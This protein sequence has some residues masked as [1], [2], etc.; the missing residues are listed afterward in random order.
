MDV[1]GLL[2]C[3]ACTLDHNATVRNNAELQLKQISRTPGFLGACLDIISSL[4]VPENVKLSACLYFKNKITN[5]WSGAKI[6]R[7]ELLNY[8]VDNDEKPVIKDMLMRAMISCSKNS[9]RCTRVLKSAL[10]T[11]IREEYPHKRWDTLLPESVALLNE[12]D[13]DSAYVGLICLS[14]IFRTYRWKE[15]DARQSLEILILDSFPGLLQYAQE[16][17]IQDGKNI[18]NVKLGEMVKLILKMYKFVIYHDLPFVLQ[19][20]DMFIN[21]ANFFVSII[22]L[23][24]PNDVINSC[25]DELQNNYSWVKCK[26]WSYAIVFRLFQ[27]YASE[28]LTKRFN[29]DEFKSLFLT[30]FFGEYLQLLFQ[31]I[32]Q[33][34]NKKLW[35]SDASIFYV[36]SFIEQAIIQ[37]STWGNIKSHYGTILEHVI[38][39]LLM[40]SEAALETFENDPQEYIHRYSDLWNDSYAPDLAAASLLATAVSKREGTTLQPTLEFTIQTLQNNVGDFRNIP[41]QNALR[42]ESSFRIF[43][44]IIDRL[45]DEQ[46]TYKNEIE[47]FLVS[48]VFP[49]FD[50]PYGFLRSRVCEISSKVG[51]LELHPSNVETLFNGIMRNLNDSDKCLPVQLL[52]ALA[53]QA[54]INNET[55]EKGLSE[56]VVPTMQLLLQLSNDFESDTISGVMQDF[57]ENFAQQ[58][59]PFGVELMNTL[60][61]QFLKLAVELHDASNFQPDDLLNDSDLPDESEK[62]MA[63]LGILSTTCSILLSFENSQNVVKNLEQSFYPAAEFILKNDVEDFYRECCEFVENSTFLLREISPISWKIL[64]LIGEAN[65]KED[66]MVSFYLEDFMLAIN[67]YTI[68]AKKEL[69]QNDFYSKILF[70][71]YKKASISEDS[72]LDELSVVFDLSQKIILCLEG[73]MPSS[74]RQRFLED[75]ARAIVVEKDGLKKNIIFGVTAFNV[76]ISSLVTSPTVT[77]QFLKHH[78]IL[79]FFFEIWLT[80]YVPNFKRVYDIK[81]STLALLSILCQ[82][83]PDHLAALSL[84][85]VSQK[86]GCLII[87]LLSRFPAALKGLQDKRREFSLDND[88]TDYYNNHGDEIEFEEKGEDAL[89]NA[90]EDHLKAFANDPDSIKFISANEFN[91]EEDFD[92]LEEDP[93]SGSVLENI[94]IYDVFKSSM[95]GLQNTDPNRYA[96]FLQTMSAE[97]QNALNH[98]MNL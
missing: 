87:E 15:N 93:L 9:A 1:N 80:F 37:K 97:D 17:L 63:A 20:E 31:Q 21:W 46:S 82:L 5:G 34:G 73:D 77:L 86:M 92:D 39:P 76:V 2:Q 8:E 4:D 48:Y 88:A 40:P 79:E 7:N 22:Q 25:D 98:L 30:Q 84:Q 96:A 81:L 27:R 13:I 58:L 32:E 41:L 65:S 69:K 29:Y 26:K 83:T 19:R 94:S 61:Q 38:F 70:E 11:I 43:S 14:E 24:L 62:Q 72:T 52:A 89:E 16:H 56:V 57:V 68:Y 55:F 64:E 78:N 75:V 71:I 59:H 51:F 53:L 95:A 67:N 74:Y 10:N 85:P 23:P 35:L 54:F 33:W 28:S 66:S 90:L 47:R 91:D 12:G 36:L 49:F 18:G 45:T 3:F 50:S 44:C 60:V 6:S 42:V